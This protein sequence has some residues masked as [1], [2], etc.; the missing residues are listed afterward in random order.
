MRLRIILLLTLVFALSTSYADT[1][2][3]KVTITA[4]DGHIPQS[5]TLH[6]Y[7][8]DQNDINA[9][10][11]NG[12]YTLRVPIQ[13]ACLYN[14]RFVQ[15]SYDI[16]LSAVDKEPTVSIKMAYDQFKDI[17]IEKCREN[18]AYKKFAAQVKI[19]DGKLRTK[20]IECENDENCGK[21]LNDLLLDY[22]DELN[23]IK[24][25]YKGTY[26]AEVFCKM[27]MPVVAK[28]VKNTAAEYRAGFFDGVPFGERSILANPIYKDMIDV[29]TDFLIE[30]RI[31][32]EEAFIKDL[33]NKA[34]ADPK[35]LSQTAGS[36]YESLFKRSREKMLSIFI[37]WYNENKEAVNNP[38]IDVKVKNLSKVMPGQHYLDI[39]R[40]DVAGKPVAL[41]DVVAGSKCTLLLFWSSD[42]SHCR[43]EMPLI[44]EMYEK[45]HAKG[46]DIYAASLEQDLTKWSSYIKENGLSWTNVP[47]QQEAKGNPAIDYMVTT[48]PT[49]ILI[50][51]SGVI[52]HRFV[53]KNKLEKYLGEA[54]K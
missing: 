20:Y 38:V 36:L 19:Y 27:R 37:S 53:P 9:N 10:L 5:V 33:M 41:K 51:K 22:S 13:G 6:P 50:D 3:L 43:E 25:K 45:Y 34:K 1:I 28:D 30:P 42:C 49:L 47:N 39:E 4:V 16:M 7:A 46:F 32:K 52:L 35:V 54:M 14:L 21:G 29:Y 11:S 12:V 26:T 48:T 44:K 31:S 23:D 24:N 8:G 40:K 2:E 15:T 17:T 18:E